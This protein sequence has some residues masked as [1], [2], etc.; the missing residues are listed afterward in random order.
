MK[1]LL[2]I[3]FLSN[4]MWCMAQNSI[5]AYCNQQPVF[6]TYNELNVGKS[7]INQVNVSVQ[8]LTG[9]NSLSNWK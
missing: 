3:V 4:G 1:K 7:Q 9:Q 5:S 6:N 8:R 2:M